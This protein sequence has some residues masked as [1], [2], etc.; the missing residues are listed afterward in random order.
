MTISRILQVLNTGIIPGNRN[1]DNIDKELANFSFILYPS[2]TIHTT[3]LRAAILKSFGFGQVGGEVLV[4]HPDYIFGA[5]S[6]EQLSE[7][8]QK[9]RLRE[10]KTYRYLHDAMTGVSPMVK[11]KNNPPYTPDL[12]S[13][14]YLNPLART[15]Y[16]PKQNTWAFDKSAVEKAADRLYAEGLVTAMRSVGDAPLGVGV[17][18]QLIT[19]VDPNNKNFIERN[20]TTKEQE[21]SLKQPCSQSSFAGRWAAKEAV[22]KALCNAHGDTRPGWLKGAGSALNSIEILPSG[23]GAPTVTLHGDLATLAVQSQQPSEQPQDTKFCV[24]VS[25]SHSGSYAVAFATVSK[26]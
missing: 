12:E 3:G 22:L 13:Q 17:D 20:F 5:L 11:L 16:D 14:V 2:R 19:D 23:S 26:C 18:V 7:Y 8:T 21:Y 25:I 15:S 24:R 6:E 9:R 1:A 4:V 10:H